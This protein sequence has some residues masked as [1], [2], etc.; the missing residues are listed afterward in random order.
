M[1]NIGTKRLETDQLI[2]RMFELSDAEP[3]FAIVF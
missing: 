2:L 3:M 1:R